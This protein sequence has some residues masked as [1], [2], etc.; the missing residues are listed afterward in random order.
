MLWQ[1]QDT[2]QN[3]KRKKKYK[4]VGENKDMANNSPVDDAMIK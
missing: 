3:M 1:I 4:L 2:I